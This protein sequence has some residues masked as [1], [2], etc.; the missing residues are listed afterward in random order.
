MT[1]SLKHLFQSP[2]SDGPDSTFVRPSNWNAEHKLTQL[3]GKLLGRPSGI[4]DGDTIEIGV[5]DNFDFDS[6]TLELSE[7]MEFPGTGAFVPPSGATSGRPA[8]PKPGMIRYNTDD[9]R[10]EKFQGGSWIDLGPTFTLD[11]ATTAEFIANSNDKVTTVQKLW[12]AAVPLVLTNGANITP[13]LGLG[14]NFKITVGGVVTLT[15]PTN[16]KPGQSGYIMITNGGGATMAFGSAWKWIQGTD[17]IISLG[18]GVVDVLYFCVLD[19]GF[20]HAALGKALA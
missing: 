11:P 1:L 3:A 9:A 15:N 10:L 12:A 18:A 6:T 19:S 2:K 17:G 8:S 14:L 16:A 20:V 5:S 13:D 7:A 4:A